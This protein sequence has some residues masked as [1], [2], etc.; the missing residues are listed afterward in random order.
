MQLLIT[1]LPETG[2]TTFLAALWHVIESEEVP[3]SLIVSEVHGIRDYLN[4]IREDW[5]NCEALERT[6]IAVQKNVSFRLRDVQTGKVL[7]LSMPDLSGET[8][9]LQWESRQWTGEFE[10]L[11]S[12]SSGVLLFMHPRTIVEPVRIDSV[13]PLVAVLEEGNGSETLNS[14]PNSASRPQP[15]DPGSQHSFGGETT[16]KPWSAADTATQ[17]KVVEILQFLRARPF[18]DRL[19]PVVVVVSAWDLISGDKKPGGWLRERLPLL[20]QF[21]EANTGTVPFVVFGISAQGAELSEAKELQQHI[22]AS[23]R[24]IVTMPD[25]ST[26]HDITAPLKWLLE[27]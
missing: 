10:K 26:N 20:H 5:L 1:G 6:K 9:R 3:G 2:K 18:I 16:T 12:E 15:G 13:E 8:F 23:D 24:I 27:R 25:G 21:L 7:E 17:V 19:L 22:K 4:K 11:A 14:L